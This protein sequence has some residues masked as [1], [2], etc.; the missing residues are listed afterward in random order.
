MVF[1]AIGLCHVSL[2]GKMHR[3]TMRSRN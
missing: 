1:I 2:R 3:P